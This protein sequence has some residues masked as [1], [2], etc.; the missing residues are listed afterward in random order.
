MAP[1]PNAALAKLRAGRVAI[2]FS[3]HHL[4]SVSVPMMARAAGFDWLFIDMEHGALS[5]QEAT[6]L[7]IAALPT[8]ITPIVRVCGGA[9]DEGTRVLDNGAQ[10]LVIPH[11]NTPTQA[12]RV[13][14]AFRYPP[15]GSRSWGGGLAGYGYAEVDPVT[16]QA[17]LDHDVLL[18][19]MIETAEAVANAEA[20][21]S[22]PGIDAVLIGSSDLT[23]DMGISGQFGHVKIRSA[24]ETVINACKKHGKHPGMGGIYDE[25]WAAAYTKMGARFNLG[26][27][28]AFFIMQAARARAKFFAEL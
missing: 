21:A 1:I 3:V 5:L 25:E 28:D 4:R 27:S 24:Y 12:R 15:Q 9:F 6:Q 20:I 22:I 10:G 13:V 17:E 23:I 11:I 19:C 7:C 26:G 14:D 16:A 18:C 8:G 2:A